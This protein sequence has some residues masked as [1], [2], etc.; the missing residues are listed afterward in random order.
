MDKIKFGM[1]GCGTVA[2]YG[3]LPGITKAE[4]AELVAV[5]GARSAS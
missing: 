2:G 5:S 3:H 1:I 4:G